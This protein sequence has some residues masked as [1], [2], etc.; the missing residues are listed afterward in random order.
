MV[1]IFHAD[2]QRQIAEPRTLEFHRAVRMFQRRFHFLKHRI[3]FVIRSDDVDLPAI[4]I[5]SG[6]AG[7][8]STLVMRDANFARRLP[9]SAT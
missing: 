9:A 6:F 1:G 3:I 2:M 5:N 4:G 8:A 7:V